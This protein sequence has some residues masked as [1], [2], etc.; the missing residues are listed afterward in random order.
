MSGAGSRH[1]RTP[2]PISPP[3]VPLCLLVFFIPTLSWP[4]C[5]DFRSSVR[6]PRRFSRRMNFEVNIMKQGLI[7]K[8]CSREFT[9]HGRQTERSSRV[10]GGCLY[11][12]RR[13]LRFDG[14]DG[15]SCRRLAAP[16]DGTSGLARKLLRRIWVMQ[17]SLWQACQNKLVCRRQIQPEWL[18]WEFATHAPP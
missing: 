16:F 6:N 5:G 11:R 15:D 4:L 3:H 1:G 12:M 10:Y 14:A 18:D 9:Q 8:G 2:S 17:S 7:Q 13:A